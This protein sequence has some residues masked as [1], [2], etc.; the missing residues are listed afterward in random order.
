MTSATVRRQ[1]DV[2]R[3]QDAAGDRDD[4]EDQAGVAM[5]PGDR[6]ASGRAASPVDDPVERH[7]RE[8]Q[9]D[10][11]RGGD[12]GRGVHVVGERVRVLEP[13]LEGDGEQEG[14]QDLGA[15]LGQPQLL[16]QLV[17]LPVEPLPLVLVCAVVRR[18][19]RIGH[20]LDGT[21]LPGNG[22]GAAHRSV[23]G[24]FISCEKG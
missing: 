13:G 2:E 20:V 15:G 7:R 6:A 4:Q 23:C 8:E 17:P 9:A 11:E 14:E 18:P 24:P 12:Q 10:G 19:S 16:Q 1:D 5:P 3:Q 22:E 21:T